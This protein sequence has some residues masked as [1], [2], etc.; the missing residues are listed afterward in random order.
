VGFDKSVLPS[1]LTVMTQRMED[2]RSVAVGAWVRTGARDERPEQLGIAHFIEHMMFKG[3][4]RR[5]ARAIAAS[6]ESLGGHLD[7]FTTR[8]YVCYSAR[9]LSEHL[10]EAIDVLADILCRSR[11]DAVEVE[12]EKSVVREEIDAY[13]D[14]PD[15]KVADLLAEQ[16]W[17]DHPLGRP[18]LGHPETLERF[19]PDALRA[20]VASR[21]RADQLVVA[22]AGGL[23]HA[24]LVELV[25]A[26][27]QPPDGPAPSRGPAPLPFLPAVRHVERDV[28]QLYLSLGTRAVAYEDPRRWGLYVLETLLGGGMSSRLFQSI[29]EE[30]GLAYS[31]FSSLDFHRDGGALSVHLGVSPERGREALRLLREELDR[32]AAAGPTDGE[33]DSAKAQLRGS[34]MMGQEST[35]NRMVHLARQ[36]LFTGAYVPPDEQVTRIAAVTPAQVR[37]LAAAFARPGLF[38][39][40]ALG[41]VTGG[42]LTEA[43]WPVEPPATR[44]E[45]A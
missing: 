24:N 13:E 5:D 23:E 11:Y 15:E 22:G 41:P 10:P 39:L 20:D 17:G 3:T 1:G 26:S 7:A 6:L 32:L 27:F 19:T 25:A 37:E 30:A 4:E 35:S 8:E 36:E 33:V 2:R 21:Y 14:N 9:S 44:S 28:N 43:D 16:I 31:V 29:R 38:A 34:V 18:I 12:R 45:A 42:A 40:V